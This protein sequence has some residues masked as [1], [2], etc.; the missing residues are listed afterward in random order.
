MN[1]RTQ[2]I[3]VLVVVFT[4]IAL[5]NLV[6][7]DKLQL[8]YALLWFV[9]GIGVGVFAC[10]PDLTAFLADLMGIYTPVNMLFFS[11]FCFSLAIIFSLSVAVSRLSDRVKKLAQEIALLKGERTDNMDS[12]VERRKDD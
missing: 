11:G 9:L 2:I 6:C 5:I 8:K 4:L 10:F 12:S 3:V 7:R 1:I